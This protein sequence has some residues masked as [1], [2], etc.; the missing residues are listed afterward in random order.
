M[1]NANDEAVINGNAAKWSVP[2][3]RHVTLQ[4]E[5]DAVVDKCQD[6]ERLLLQEVGGDDRPICITRTNGQVIGRL[7]TADTLQV[8]FNFERGVMHLAFLLSQPTDS[9]LAQIVV[10]FCPP[11]VDAASC[12]EH[13]DH[14]FLDSA[15]SN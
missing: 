1:V 13:I 6:K 8:R 14:H 15:V 11:G 4:I 2:P 9:D 5:S 10:V 7:S 3:I 12:C